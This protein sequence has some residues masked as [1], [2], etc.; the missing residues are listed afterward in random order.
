MI[1][2]S[3]QRTTRQAQLHKPLPITT[4]DPLSHGKASMCPAQI[5]CPNQTYAC[6]SGLAYRP[7]KRAPGKATKHLPLLSGPRGSC[8][9]PAART[10][11]SLSSK[12]TP[13]TQVQDAGQPSSM[14]S[15]STTAMYPFRE[16][17]Q[18]QHPCIAPASFMSSVYL[19]SYVLE[20]LDVEGGKTA[21]QG[22]KPPC[23]PSA[24]TGLGDLRM[25]M[26]IHKHG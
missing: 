20:H 3:S 11:P 2:I 13:C 4:T 24:A 19:Q 1:A 23:S 7:N 16:H 5:F 12:C 14:Y 25:G 6:R 8:P 9:E 26:Q 10:P 18:K 15:A 22:G 17:Q 21:R